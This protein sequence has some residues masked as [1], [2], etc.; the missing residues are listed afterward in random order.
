MKEMNPSPAARPLIRQRSR[1]LRS[2][3]IGNRAAA[4]AWVDASREGAGLFA[5][6]PVVLPYDVVRMRIRRLIGAR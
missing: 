5:A 2:D 3:P 4:P 1:Q 6:T